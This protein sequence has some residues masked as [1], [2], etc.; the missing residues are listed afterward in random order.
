MFRDDFVM[1]K[2][3][4]KKKG[5]KSVVKEIILNLNEKFILEIQRGCAGNN[6]IWCPQH[7]EHIKTLK[8]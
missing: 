7:C 2:T 3:I 8:Y 4:P 6:A 1:H 5:P